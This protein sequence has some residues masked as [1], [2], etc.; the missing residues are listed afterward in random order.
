MVNFTDLSQAVISG[1]EAG[2]KD[3]TKS[4]I[5]AG[6]KP[7]DIINQG[8]IGGM[9][10]VGVRFKAGDMFVPEVLMAARSMAAGVELVKPLI[11][12]KDMP[13]KGTVVLGTVKGD[14]HDIGKNLVAML[15]ESAGYKV[16]NMGT[17][18]ESEK[19]V[20]AVKEQ[21]P[22]VVALSALLTTTMLKMK[23]VVDLL[24]EAGLR[25]NVKVIIGGAP[26]SQEYADEI[27][28]DGYASD[29]A[30]A[31]ELCDKLLGN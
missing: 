31:T 21:K 30:S 2:V 25:G 27:G 7:I 11:A 3:L 28:A 15:M 18:V 9:N 22:D 14:L 4:L 17:D 13:S 19:F 8:L 29:A 20:E 24:Q 12:E 10:V 1:N 16:I 5:D 6:E 26:I 23:E